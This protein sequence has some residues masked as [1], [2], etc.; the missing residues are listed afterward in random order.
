MVLGQQKQIVNKNSSAANNNAFVLLFGIH[1]FTEFNVKVKNENHAI[2]VG[3]KNRS[4]RC[5]MNLNLEYFWYN[6]YGS[7]K[8]QAYLLSSYSRHFNIEHH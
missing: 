5:K 8:V 2:K 7:S 1:R 4:I 6:E 3:K